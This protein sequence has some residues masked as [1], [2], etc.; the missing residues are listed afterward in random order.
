MEKM[1]L[2]IQRFAVNIQFTN[3]QETDINIADNTSK[4]KFD[5]E[6]ITSG[7]TYNNTGSA[8]YKV[9]IKRNSD[10][11][12]IYDSGK[13]K[14]NISKNTTKDFT[15]TS[16]AIQH[17]SNGSY[18]S[19]LKCTLYVYL[20]STTDKTYN[21]NTSLSTIP[22]ASTFTKSVSTLTLGNPVTFTITRADS[23]FTHDLRYEGTYTGTIATG[24][25]TSYVWTPATSLLPGKMTD[26]VTIYCDTIYNGEVIGTT[27]TTMTLN[28]P[29]YTPTISLALYDTNAT[30]RA[31][32]VY[33]QSKSSMRATITGS[34]SYDGSI[35]TY[36]IRMASSGDYTNYTSNVIYPTINSNGVVYA[37]ITDSREQTAT[38]NASYTYV[39]YSS[40][41]IDTYQVQRCDSNGNIDDN[42]DYCYI[43]FHASISS[44][45][46]N[47]KAGTTYKIKYKLS[48]ASTYTEVTVGSNLDTL[49]YN[50]IFKD[51]NNNKILFSS[52]DKYDFQ[53]YV[54]DT[55][56][57]AVTINQE[58]DTGF[59]LLNFNASG[60]AIAIGKVS[61]AGANEELLEVN[62]P[63]NFLNALKINNQELIA[64][65]V[66]YE[67]NS[68]TN[69]D[70]ALSDAVTNYDYIEIFYANS[71]DETL[72]SV[73]FIPQV[74]KNVCLTTYNIDTFKFTTVTAKYLINYGGMYLKKSGETKC[75]ITSS[76]VITTPQ[77][78][79]VYKV[80][81]WK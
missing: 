4:L 62:L 11:V 51:A 24:V 10:N 2:N 40:P 54:K 75:A 58:I 28:T 19:T 78:I 73:K 25:D 30:T 12:Q 36:G 17:L 44:C 76:A 26:N 64:P 72:S 23:S 15:L 70:F 45:N 56:S 38:T 59:D 69:T 71:N 27:S 81:G 60:K 46:G 48:T 3:I 49:N 31:W 77:Q 34:T 47:N 1:K 67:N 61:S 18:D 32:G 39:S 57:N 20:T 43:N 37:K 63:A 7:A 14:F 21:Q 42:G 6:I 9:T 29:S 35:S 13:K 79:Y 66:L 68:G 16:N 65:Y 8:Y 52:N 53:F 5:I 80:V 33:V 41:K 22:R 74:S 50:Q 55:L